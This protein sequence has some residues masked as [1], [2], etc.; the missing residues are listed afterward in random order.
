MSSTN[1]LFI[2]EGEVTELKLLNKIKESL[3]L[4][5]DFNIY[6]YKT[7]I[8]NLYKDLKLDDDLDVALYLKEK[9]TSRL[10][11]ELLSKEFTAIYLIFDLEPQDHDFDP[12]KI[13]LLLTF[14]NDSTD[15][16][17]LLINYPMVESFKHLKS[18]C[19]QEFVSRSLP[20]AEIKNY[21]E[22]VSLE[23]R[24]GKVE[25]YHHKMVMEMIIHH[26]VKI[27]YILTGI[28]EFPTVKQIS[29]Y[30]EEHSLYDKQ[31]EHL[32]TGI[33]FPVSTLYYFLIDLKPISFYD[34]FQLPLIELLC[35]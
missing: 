22:I 28:K 2:V 5:E 10:K 14:F 27:Q 1:V 7:N 20:L 26:L 17:K 13:K 18:L 34:Q 3:Y 21:K 6:P 29:S 30:I 8:F 23:T 15:K 31:I 11:K 12:E 25:D 19:D 16:G 32:V 9:E 35:K 24:Y 4:D 33:I